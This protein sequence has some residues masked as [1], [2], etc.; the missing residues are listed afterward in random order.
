M[1]TLCILA[2]FAGTA[3]AADE[4]PPVEKLIEQL[5]SPSFPVR[6]RAMKQ[7]RERGPA[8]LPALRKAMESKDEEV[9]KR[10]G[11]LIPPLEIEEALLPKRVTLKANGQSAEAAVADLGRQTGFKLAAPG[12]DD[13]GKKVTADLKDVPFWEAMDKVGQDAGRTPS[14]QQ[15]DKTLQLITGVGRSPFV[16]VRGPFRL[17]ATWFHED[18]DV[19]FRRTGGGKEAPRDRRLTLSVSVLAE[20]RLTFLKVH[21][22]KVEEAVDSDGKSLLEPA[23]APKVDNPPPGR[24]TFRGESTAYSDVRLRRASESAKTAK[25][26][27]GTIPVRTVLIRKQIVVTNKLMESTGTAF[28][29]GTDSLQITRVQNQGGNNVEVQLLIPRDRNAGWSETEKWYERFHVEDDAGHRFQ[30]H[31][32][33]SSSNG[34][35]YWI[36]IYCGPPNGKAVG[37][38]TKL[39]FEDWVVHEHA[40]PFEFR[41]V[42][43]P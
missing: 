35:Q 39:V 13:P 43:L 42:P 26:I 34:N 19:D 8:A 21:P 40:I 6:E 20:P 25:V 41:D 29:A 9:R 18:R 37:P 11:S 17:E 27:R 12:A 3:G 4:P 15:Y 36:S 22:A 23:G 32:R 30:D 16:N 24:G 2:L 31:G 28:R 10:A 1:R 7:L 14:F 38:P 33:G 5:G